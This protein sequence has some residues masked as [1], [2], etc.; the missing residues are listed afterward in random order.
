MLKGTEV[1]GSN[2]TAITP[3]P[4]ESYLFFSVCCVGTLKPNVKKEKKKAGEPEIP[5]LTILM[6]VS[7]VSPQTARQH[8]FTARPRDKEA[9]AEER[10]AAGR[11]LQQLSQ[12]TLGS[13]EDFVEV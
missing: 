9:P 5:S 1:P 7:T 4:H 2:I 3:L 13:V 8:E 6:T 10:G 11:H 12:E